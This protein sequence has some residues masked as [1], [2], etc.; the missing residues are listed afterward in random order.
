M[1]NLRE[2]ALGAANYDGAFE[3]VAQQLTPSQFERDERIAV[4]LLGPLQRKKTFSTAP[5]R[6]SEEVWAR[7]RAA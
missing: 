6:L 7:R 1:A 5:K 4:E 2:M 3:R